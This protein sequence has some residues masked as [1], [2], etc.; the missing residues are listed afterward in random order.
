MGC[1]IHV[2]G[3]VKVDGSWM[4]YS[5]MDVSRDYALFTKMA[6]V[7][8]YSNGEIVPLSEPKGLPFDA[9]EPTLFEANHFDTDGHSHSWL[10]LAELR[11]LS[12]WLAHNRSGNGQYLWSIFGWFYGNDWRLDSAP[13][14]V[15]DVRIVF[16]FDN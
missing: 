3:E 5:K 8:N 15:E 9:T 11:R 10:G 13:E 7:R 6:N 12:E 2:H 1:D 16:W 14:G 4:H